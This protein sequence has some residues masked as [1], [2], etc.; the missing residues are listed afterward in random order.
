[1]AKCQIGVRI[2]TKTHTNMT[3]LY[4][5]LNL[6]LTGLLLLPALSALFFH[7]PLAKKLVS[8]DLINDQEQFFRIQWK[9][10]SIFMSLY[11]VFIAISFYFLGTGAI[12]SSVI[13][14]VICISIEFKKVIG[15]S[16]L[17]V[18][19]FLTSN[20]KYFKDPE[21]ASSVVSESVS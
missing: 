16:S 13:N 17:S 20:H 6:I 14:C 2:D 3:W 8:L 5:F 12:I 19:S 1:V 15:K 4:Y 11:L 21:V 10:F 9:R 18:E 7:I